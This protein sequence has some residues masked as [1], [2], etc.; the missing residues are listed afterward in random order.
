MCFGNVHL[1]GKI[2]MNIYVLC[3][4]NYFLYYVSKYYHNGLWKNPNGQSSCCS[5]FQGS[6]FQDFAA[7][8]Q[9][10]IVSIPDALA[11]LSWS[12]PALAL[13]AARISDQFSQQNHLQSISGSML[14]NS[15]ARFVLTLSGWEMHTLLLGLSQMQSWKWFL[16]PSLSRMRSGNKASKLEIPMPLSSC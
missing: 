7:F 3:K 9:R 2:A 12:Y 1:G 16:I 11:E 10:A 13:K 4:W 14:N 6:V 5:V 8:H 15:Q